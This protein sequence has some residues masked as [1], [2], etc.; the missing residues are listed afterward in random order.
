M[1]DPAGDGRLLLFSEWLDVNRF[2]PE[3]AEGDRRTHDE[4]VG[5][6]LDGG[7]LEL[8]YLIWLMRRPGTVKDGLRPPPVVHRYRMER[9]E[10]AITP[11]QIAPNGQND[12]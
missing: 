11:T 12:R 4:L 3:P 7:H 6:F 8:A 2:M 1:P 5:E 10:Q 9:A